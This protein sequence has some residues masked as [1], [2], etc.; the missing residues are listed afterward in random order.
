MLIV[1]L[2]VELKRMTASLPF[3]L[4]CIRKVIYGL[5]ARFPIKTGRDTPNH[6]YTW[7]CHNLNQSLIPLPYNFKGVRS[8]NKK[9]NG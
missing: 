6:N 8:A 2:R 7:L 4:F 1:S 3:N 9:Y 5:E